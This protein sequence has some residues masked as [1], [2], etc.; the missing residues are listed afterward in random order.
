VL[1]QLLIPAAGG[2]PAY[3]HGRSTALALAAILAMVCAPQVALVAG[4]LAAW[5][6]VRRRS[7]RVLPDREVALIH[8]RSRIAAVAGLVTSAGMLAGA[9]NF[10]GQLAGWW[11]LVQAGLGGLAALALIAA[12]RRSL[13]A[14]HVV[15][16]VDGPSGGFA[17]DL[18]VVGDPASLVA[19]RQHLGIAVA[20]A[21]ILITAATVAF[22]GHAE[23]SLV[24]GLERGG[25]EAVFLIAA[26]LAARGFM[27]R[28][29]TTSRRR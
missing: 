7:L 8:R 15:G 25:F 26:A 4:L 3:D 20:A 22:T 27:R 23:R 29:T 11:V 28:S 5:R 21:I 14:W 12:V 13:D 1:G 17:A 6:A 9:Y 19:V 10:S 24:E 16:G 18:T 2:Y